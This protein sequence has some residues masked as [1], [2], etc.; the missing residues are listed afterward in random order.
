MGNKKKPRIRTIEECQK[1]IDAIYNFKQT[2]DPIDDRASNKIAFLLGEYLVLKKVLGIFPN[3]LHYGGQGHCDI[4]VPD[5]FIQIEV[6]TSL[7]KKS[8]A[9]KGIEGWGWTVE[10]EG[11]E[12]KRVGDNKPRFNHMIAVALDK[13]TWGKQEFFIIPWK[14]A[15]D[16]NIVRPIK[17]LSNIRMRIERFQNES[18]LQKAHKMSH[19][20]NPYLGPT[21]LEEVLVKNPQQF[22]IWDILSNYS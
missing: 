8:R 19:G 9:Y 13:E 3:A 21:K 11:Q 14:D 10:T 17:G 12:N 6:K 18:D 5:P 16:G 7:F 15:V 22:Q 4:I 1:I 20:T 2:L